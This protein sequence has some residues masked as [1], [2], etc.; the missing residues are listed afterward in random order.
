MYTNRKWS[1]KSINMQISAFCVTTHQT[2]KGPST[3]YV[4]LVGAGSNIADLT[5]SKKT[6]KWE[7]V[8]YCRFWDD[9]V[10]GWFRSIGQDYAL[11][12]F[13]W[14]TL[15]L[16]ICFSTRESVW[17]FHAESGSGAVFPQDDKRH[18]RV[19]SD[20]GAKLGRQANAQWSPKNS[21]IILELYEIS[22]FHLDGMRRENITGWVLGHILWKINCGLV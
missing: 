12:G 3:N 1:I 7:G 4:I 2:W 6:T 16:I 18:N 15:K 11:F 9:I 21:K 5:Y 20:H 8:K 14:S 13:Y 10:Y 22:S 19:R 17:I